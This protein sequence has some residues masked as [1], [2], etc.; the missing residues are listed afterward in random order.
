[1]KQRRITVIIF[2]MIINKIANFFL[3]FFYLLHYRNWIS[4]QYYAGR[5]MWLDSRKSRVCFI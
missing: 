4:E 5:I 1:M 3:H 2:E